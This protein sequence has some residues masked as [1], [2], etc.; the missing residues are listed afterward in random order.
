MLQSKT[1]GILVHD[2]RPVFHDQLSVEPLK[3]TLNVSDGFE[4]WWP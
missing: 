3:R 4:N 1:E 2:W